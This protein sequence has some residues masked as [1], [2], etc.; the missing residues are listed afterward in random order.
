MGF[1]TFV[2]SFRVDVMPARSLPIEVPYRN[3]IGC[4]T[5]R[6]E[7]LLPGSEAHN[8]VI[9]IRNLMTVSGKYTH[10]ILVLEIVHPGWREGSCVTLQLP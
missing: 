3:V 6:I 1:Y 10:H 9:L 2:Y 8:G 5:V 7:L 4:P